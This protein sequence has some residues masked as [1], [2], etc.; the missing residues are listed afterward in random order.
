MDWVISPLG[1]GLGYL[2]NGRCTELPQLW[3]SDWADSSK[4][5]D[6]VTS[7]HW[8][9]DWVVSPLGVG[10]GCLTTERWTGLSQHWVLDWSDLSLDVD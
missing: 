8:A 3:V 7:H 5:V 10:L 2:T 1:V 9:L 6:C 4:D